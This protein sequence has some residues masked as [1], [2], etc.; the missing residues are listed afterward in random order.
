MSTLSRRDFLKRL[1]QVIIAA[2]AAP[3][4]SFDELL[5]ADDASEASTWQRPNLVWLQGASCSGC[6]PSVFNIEQ[7]TVVDLLT[8]F[9]RVVY[10]QD[11]S[12]AT[13][14]QVVESLHQLITSK[15]PYIFILEGGIPVGMPHA[16]VM[17]DRPLTAWVKMLA[18]AAAVTIAAGTCAASGGVARMPG[19]LTGVATLQ[20]FLVAEKITTPLVNLPAC[21]MKP[22]HL[23]YTLLHFIR[24]NT[25]PELDQQHRPHQFF[26]HTIHHLCPRYGAFQ[27]LDF[28]RH[29]GEAGCLLELG[30]QGPTTYND[31]SLT[32]HNGNINICI[33]AG[34][35]CIGCAGELFPRTILYHL[36]NDPRVKDGLLQIASPTPEH[37]G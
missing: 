30:C 18:E 2:G 26:A 16:C 8:T 19:T 35:P 3:L 17:A 34:H 7:I 37:G 27:E 4:L 36:H 22:E 31:C 6:S 1:Y 5:A 28:A 13:G 21:P 10:H 15:E 33:R 14:H 29:I 23:V 20:E 11:L 25:V 12:L 32:G 9:T 24:R